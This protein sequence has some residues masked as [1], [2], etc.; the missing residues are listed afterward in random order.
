MFDTSAKTSKMELQELLNAFAFSRHVELDRFKVN[1]I[2]KTMLHALENIG[3]PVVPREVYGMYETSY[4]S[5]LSTRVVFEQ[6]EIKKNARLQRF[7]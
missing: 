4:V 5:M 3:S 2:C 7:D 6:K 1:V